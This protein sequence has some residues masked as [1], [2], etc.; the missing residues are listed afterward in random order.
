VEIEGP[1]RTARCF[2]AEEVVRRSLGVGAPVSDVM[3]SQDGAAADAVL[4]VA[5]LVGR[6]GEKEILH[7]VDL[8]VPR[9]SCVAV[10]GESGSGK[11]TLA[12]CLV[13]LHG[14]WSGTVAFDSQSVRPLARNR[15]LKVLQAVQYVFQ[16]PYTALNPRKT[17]GQ[18]VEQPLAHFYKLAARERTARVVAALEA[19]ALNEDFLGRYPDQLSGGERQRVAIARALVVEPEL[20][21]CDEVTSA[22]DVSVQAAIVELLR[23]LQNERGLSLLFITHNL[24]LV[25]SIAQ[26]VVVLH[27]GSVVERGPTDTVL[28]HPVDEYTIRLLEDV[29]KLTSLTDS[30]HVSAVT[31]V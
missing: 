28:S 11:T 4:V 31:P 3:V 12:R 13:G 18:L 26:E 19:A 20:L 25:R 7:G 29:P 24:A 8:A 22:L 10:V 27:E 1:A 14:N 21:V 9:G 16:S 6:Y 30:C 15:S 5:G 23:R 17:I 2:R